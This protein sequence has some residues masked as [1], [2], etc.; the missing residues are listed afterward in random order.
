MP[1]ILSALPREYRGDRWVQSL[2]HAVQAADEAQRTRADEIA[3]QIL[4]D[5]L[6]FH[7][8]AEERIAGIRP[9]K[10]ASVADRLSALS[11]KWRS[12]GK[13]DLDQIQRVCDAWKDG[14]VEVQ[15]EA[16]TIHL[17]FVGAFGVPADMDGLLAAVGD[18]RPAH[19]AITYALRYLL[20]REVAGMT[21]GAL[22]ACTIDQFAF[23]RTA[24]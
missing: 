11:A 15:Y 7:L 8:E 18:M 1:D 4:L 13:V 21:V 10:G 20:V 14:E 2:L 19:L 22:T 16:D 9:P 5:T 24:I 6:T 12:G 3:A 17:L 23:G